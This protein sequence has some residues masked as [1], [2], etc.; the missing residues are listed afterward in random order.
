MSHAPA[1]NLLPKGRLLRA[2]IGLAGLGVA[3]AMETVAVGALPRILRLGLGVGGLYF[4]L[5]G[6]AQALTGT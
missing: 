3:V 5:L 2:L 6:L 4:G 1:Q